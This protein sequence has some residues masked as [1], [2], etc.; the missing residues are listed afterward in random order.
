MN[1]S[2]QKYVEV[3]VQKSL[4]SGTTTADESGNLELTDSSADFVTDG[5]KAND[6]VHDTSDDR[7]YVVDTVVDLNTVSL[8]AIGSTSGTGLESGKNYIIYASD[9]STKQLIASDGVV[10]VEND[11]VDPINSEVNIQYSGSSGIVVKITHAATAAGSEAMRDGFEEAVVE[12][13]QQ[14][15]PAV[16]YEWDLPSSLVLNIATV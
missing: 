9:Q 6:V 7:M 14:P 10:L 16:K 5:I 8:S 3:S 4:A 2:M 13:L 12:S 1:S 11:P 15:W